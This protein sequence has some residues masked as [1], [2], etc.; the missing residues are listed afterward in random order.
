MA[1]MSFSFL[2]ATLGGS[3][4]SAL[5]FVSRSTA[6]LL[7]SVSTIMQKPRRTSA[8]SSPVSTIRRCTSASLVVS[9][10]LHIWRQ[11]WPAQP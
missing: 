6:A 9:M 10:T 11:L 4:G 1:K 5:P 3:R 8:L 2:L 7:Y